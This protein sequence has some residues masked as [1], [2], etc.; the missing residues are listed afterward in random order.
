MA[1]ENKFF[2]EVYAEHFKENG[3]MKEGKFSQ[4]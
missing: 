1:E 3:L 2:R 4:F